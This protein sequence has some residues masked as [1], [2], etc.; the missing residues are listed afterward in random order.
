MSW[1]RD[2]LRGDGARPQ[3]PRELLLRRLRQDR[4]I[5]ADALEA[6]A[7]VPRELFVPAEHG[8]VAYEDVALEI[9]P[10]ATIS[11]PS[12]VAEMLTA[13]KLTPG[14]SVLEIG[15]GSGYAAATIASYGDRVVSVEVQ[16]ELAERARQN[17][18]RSG[19]SGLVRTVTADGRGG[20]AEGA[21]YDRILVSASVEAVPQAWLD[22]LA[23]GGI[24][25]YPESGRDEDLLV[26]LGRADATLTREVMGR[27]RFVRM[28]L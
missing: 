9:G 23:P 27:C 5:S 19:F 11:A 25:V 3:H 26:R 1:A 21:P 13:L 20:W 8:E 17:L 28:Q 14:L 22:Q 2:L 18:E 7:R 10:M 15:G 24:L 16:G 4:R 12:M 6:I